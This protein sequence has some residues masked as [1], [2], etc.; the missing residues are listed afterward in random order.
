MAASD[1]W[2]MQLNNFLQAHGGPQILGWTVFTTGPQHQPMW[3]AITYVR[4]V[5]YA[6]VHGSSQN[7]VKEEAARRTLAALQ[8]D[9]RRW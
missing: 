2:R 1:H 4:G 7:A 3:T 8:A 5:E 9:R 6:K